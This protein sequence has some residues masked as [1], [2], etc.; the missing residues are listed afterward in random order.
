[1][2]LTIKI[3]LDNEELKDSIPKLQDMLEWLR[4]QIYEQ[5]THYDIPDINGNT[6]GYAEITE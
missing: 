2:E 4:F 3:N 1:M 6:V 5:G